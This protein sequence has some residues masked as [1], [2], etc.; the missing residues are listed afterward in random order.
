MKT[1]EGP[2]ENILTLEHLF[3]KTIGNKS[4]LKKTKKFLSHIIQKRI[5]NFYTNIRFN[6]IEYIKKYWKT[7]K[8]L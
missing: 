7:V 5:R 4:K 8:P 6:N 3:K 1:K 2:L